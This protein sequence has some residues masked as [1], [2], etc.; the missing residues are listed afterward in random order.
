MFAAK[1]WTILISALAIAACGGGGG[2]N[3]SGNTP[4]P[5]PRPESG[6]QT[7]DQP[8]LFA[9]E[10]QVHVIYAVPH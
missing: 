5:P 7:T 10:Y 6:R 3:S 1:T 4:P 2:N 8:D 9:D